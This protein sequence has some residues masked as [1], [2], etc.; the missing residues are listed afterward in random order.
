MQLQTVL[1][2]SPKVLIAGIAQNIE[3]NVLCIKNIFQKFKVLIPE[4]DMVIY[5]NNSTDTTKIKLNEWAEEDPR[6]HILCE[7]FTD[8]E[9]KAQTTSR[10]IYNNPSK[11]ETKCLARNKLL[12]MLSQ[13]KFQ[14]YTHVILMNL[15]NQNPPPVQ[16]MAAYIIK[17]PCEYDAMICNGIDTKGRIYDLHAYR[18]ERYPFGPEIIGPEFWTDHHRN[19]ACETILF[20]KEMRSV[21]S[22]YNGMC[23]LRKEAI[24]GLKFSVFPS[25]TLDIMY[26]T[27]CDRFIIPTNYQYNDAPI[28]M[29]YFS[30]NSVFYYFTSSVNVPLVNPF[31]NFFLEMRRNGHEKIMINPNFIWKWYSASFTVI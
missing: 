1:E 14:D 2:S 3:Y 13:E 21:L 17:P 5:E 23:I 18:D 27:K 20:K 25:T 11:E 19:L 15:N 10:D 28:G 12:D 24:K 31:T 7:T 22:A 29:F 30:N 6:V 8:D 9:L 16:K 26:R 4:S